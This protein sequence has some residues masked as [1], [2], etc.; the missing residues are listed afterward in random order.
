MSDEAA[1]ESDTETLR[2][3]I[4][5]GLADVEAGNMSDDD[6]YERVLARIDAAAK[7]KLT[8]E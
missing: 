5:K 8:N 6:V 2:D 3:F 7:P 4:A 1:E